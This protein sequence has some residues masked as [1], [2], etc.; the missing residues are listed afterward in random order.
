MGLSNNRTTLWNDILLQPNLLRPNNTKM[1]TKNK[2]KR[3]P[4][5]II[6]ILFLLQL[7]TIISFCFIA[8][9]QVPWKYELGLKK[10]YSEGIGQET[11]CNNMGYEWDSNDG[12]CDVSP[13]QGILSKQ[14]ATHL[15]YF[16]S[17][18][19]KM[20]HYGPLDN[21]NIYTKFQFKQILS[22]KY[23]KIQ[24][25]LK[26]AYYKDGLKFEKIKTL[27]VGKK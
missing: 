3:N 4:N 12:Y 11:F 23:W 16:T 6:N 26:L 19:I 8:F 21:S 27:E 5:R 14:N 20:K 1:K 15:L 22:Y 25:K 2:K 10:G 13:K 18:W 24:Y 9:I 17:P 7:F